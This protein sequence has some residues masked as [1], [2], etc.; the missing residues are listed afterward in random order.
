MLLFLRQGFLGTPSGHPTAPVP[1]PITSQHRMQKG[2]VPLCASQAG[3]G[4]W[5]VLFS[6]GFTGL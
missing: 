1:F 6:Q 4:R 3:P 2:L 5:Q